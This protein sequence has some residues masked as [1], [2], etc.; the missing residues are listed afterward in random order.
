M[1][2]GAASSV[3]AFAIKFAILSNIPPLI[4]VAGRGAAYVETL[5]DKEKG[6]VIIDYRIGDSSVVD[7]MR[8]VLSDNDLIYAFDAVSDKG[9]YQNIMQVMDQTHGKI[10]FVL[11]RKK[12]E[13]VPDTVQKSFVQ[14]GKVHSPDYPGIPGERFPSGPLD[15]RDFGSTMYSFIARGLKKCWFRGHP[16]EVVPG[17]LNGIETALK[18]LKAGKASAVKYVFKIA[19]TDILGKNRL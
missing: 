3:G 2:Y 4:C 19:D 14:V 17:G 10:A 12:Y 16:F 7:G 18:N 6:D 5:I 1:I 8:K 9:S 13:G 11:P 15:D